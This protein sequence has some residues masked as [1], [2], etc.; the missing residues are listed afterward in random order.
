MIL[1]GIRLGR[2]LWI[3]TEGVLQ[4]RGDDKDAHHLGRRGSA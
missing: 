3:C 1:R 4:G 2:M